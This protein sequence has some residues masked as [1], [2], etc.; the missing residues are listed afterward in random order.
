MVTESFGSVKPHTLSWWIPSKLLILISWKYLLFSVGVGRLWD[1]Q[2][3]SYPECPFITPGRLQL[4]QP[5]RIVAAAAC[6]K[7]LPAFSQEEKAVIETMVVR[8]I[9]FHSSPFKDCRVVVPLL[10]CFAGK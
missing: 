3:V 10:L 2:N 6:E 8:F 5:L 1:L 4:C 7:S 9:F